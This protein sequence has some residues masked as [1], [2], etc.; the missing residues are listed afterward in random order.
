MKEQL[1][2][3]PYQIVSSPNS[4]VCYGMTLRAYIATKALS[5]M[6]VDSEIILSPE[7]Y[8]KDA[9]RYADALVSELNKI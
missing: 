4:E 3:F 1:N 9:V 7:L 6:L 2:A 8:A 5:A